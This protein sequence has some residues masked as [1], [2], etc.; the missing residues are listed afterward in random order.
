MS[1][2]KADLIAFEKDIAECFERGE[3]KGPVHLSGGNEDQLI[4]IFKEIKRTDYVCSTWR[5]HFH[6]LLHGIPP[7]RLKAAI[8]RGPS[9]NINFPEHRFL[10]SAIV[11]G[12]LPIACGIAAGIKRRGGAELVWCFIGDM[13]ATTGICA[14]VEQYA[15]NHKL[16]LR[17]VVEDNGL[18]TNTPTRDAWGE[19]NYHKPR[20]WYWYDR[21]VPHVGTGKW[22]TI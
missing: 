5:N 3:I 11:G 16:P 17:V 21:S 10:T 7:E 19:H 1:I 8:L 15:A 14:E 20:W 9:M 18:S 2:S 6:A 4:E 12:I 22:V 13:A